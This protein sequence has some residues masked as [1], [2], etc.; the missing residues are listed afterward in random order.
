MLTEFGVRFAK[1]YGACVDVLH[2]QGDDALLEEVFL[3]YAVRMYEL[4][5]DEQFHYGVLYAALK[6]KEQEIRNLTWIAEMINTNN[7]AHIDKNVVH[8]FP[9]K[10]EFL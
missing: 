3:K 4:V 2:K 9:E 7:R 1:T 6:L 10:G 8:I 5:F